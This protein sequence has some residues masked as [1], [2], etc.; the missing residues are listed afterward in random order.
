MN[1][2]TEYLH[3]Y[4][5]IANQEKKIN[6]TNTDLQREKNLNNVDL[7]A[8]SINQISFDLQRSIEPEK[9]FT[10][11]KDNNNFFQ[12]QKQKTKISFIDKII[13]QTNKLECFSF[14][15]DLVIIKYD[16]KI[17]Y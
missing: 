10:R 5:G 6:N 15:T 12:H 7:T 1:N 4:I 2:T 14:H 16:K 3:D 13:K 17:M 8:V 11:K 9:I